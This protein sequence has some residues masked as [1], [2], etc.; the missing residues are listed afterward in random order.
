MK[1][2]NQVNNNTPVTVLFCPRTPNGELAIRLR[3]A[4]MEIEVITGDKIKIVERAGI[5]IKNILVKSNPWAG[6]PCGRPD[7]LVCPQENA[8]NCRKRNCTYKTECITCKE[9]KRQGKCIYRR[10][11]KN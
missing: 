8:G 9:K 11:V 5:M 7:C 10:N 4:E 6:S 2:N 1:V 3:K